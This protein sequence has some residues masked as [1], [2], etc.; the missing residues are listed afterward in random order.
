MYVLTG[1]ADIGFTA[2]SLAKSPELTKQSN[3][4][5]LNSQSYEPIK[6][7]MILLKGAPPEAIELYRFMQ[8]EEA[9]AVLQKYGYVIP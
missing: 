1:A 9:K 7:K 6:Q 2:F 3:H 5:L 8:G 4:I